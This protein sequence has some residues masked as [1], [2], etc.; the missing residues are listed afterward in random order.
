M[1]V[2]FD[3]EN[4]LAPME[5]VDRA[6]HYG[7]PSYIERSKSKGYHVWIFFKGEV[8]AF[9]ARLVINLILEEIGAHDTEVFPKLDVLDTNT[10]YGH[11]INTPLF[12]KL[13]PKGRTVFVDPATFEPYLD[14]W[15]LLESV[16][17]A[18]E[19]TLNRIIELNGL[20]PEPKYQRQTSGSGSKKRAQFSLPPCA[21][22]MLSEG[23]S[24]YQRVSCFRLAVHLKKIGL[25]YDATLSVL[26]VWAM[27]NKPTEGN[28]I[29]EDSEIIAQSYYAYENSYLGY[30]CESPAVRPFCEASCP[31]KEWREKNE[32]ALSADMN[33]RYSLSEKVL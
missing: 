20:Y 19:T 1:V 8:L 33:K 4:E 29:I 13:V 15:A 31:V 25:P 11:F 26:R 21:Q 6:K 23:V 14:Q 24:Q 17:K 22:R 28:S 9:K 16:Q 30:G 3:T 27:K 12:G 5:F 18:S 2:D 7:V 10:H 32:E